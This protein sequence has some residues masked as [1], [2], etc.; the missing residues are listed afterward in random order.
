MSIRSSAAGA[1]CLA[2]ALASPSPM[3]A[4]EPARS[5]QPAASSPGS[6]FGDYQRFQAPPLRPW[7]QA[8]QEVAQSPAMGGMAHTP[9]MNMPTAGSQPGAMAGHSMPGMN[10]PSPSAQTGSMTGHS[11]PGMNMPAGGSRH[12]ATSAHAMPATGGHGTAGDAHA[13][14]AGMAAM[15]GMGGKQQAASAAGHGG[16]AEPKAT[17]AGG[18]AMAPM[19]GMPGMEGSRS[20]PADNARLTGTGIVRSIDKAAA[21][22]KLTH[23]PVAA[24]GWP[25]MTLVFRLADSALADRVKQGDKVAFT[26]T[27]S[28]TGY[29]ISELRPGTAAQAAK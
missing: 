13:A 18:A 6:V 3:S 27:R 14:M 5:A 23:D 26:L 8:N 17:A 4:Q 9:G 1:A 25:R 11:M 10:M 7:A 24:A 22:V 16:H 2:L 28:A 20:M 15:P 29:V 19:R 12:R 21:R